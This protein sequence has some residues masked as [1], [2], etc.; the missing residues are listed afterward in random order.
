MKKKMV[1]TQRVVIILFREARNLIHPQSSKHPSKQIKVRITMSVIQRYG[2]TNNSNEDDKDQ[3][4][5][6]MQSIIAKCSRK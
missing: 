2:P 6:R 3:F 5:A 4:Y 1:H